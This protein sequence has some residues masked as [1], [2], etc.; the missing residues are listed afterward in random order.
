MADP[1]LHAETAHQASQQL[2]EVAVD[3]CP[4]ACAHCPETSE[5]TIT[6]DE[7]GGARWRSTSRYRYGTFS[8]LIKCPDGN[9]SG[10]NFNIYLSSLE[11][12][13]SQDEIDFEFLGKDK[14]IVQTNYYTTGTGS[15]EEIHELGF[16]CSDDF[17]EYTI[18]WFPDVIEWLIDGKVV[19]RV[20]KETGSAFPDKPMFLYASVW[21]ASYIDEGRWTGPYL[22]YDSP[23]V[24]R[25]RNVRVPTE[26]AIHAPS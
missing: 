19:R 4:E 22:A 7:R 3:Y 10:L 9:T 18:K 17:H 26:T 21:D 11:G 1:A 8:A 6:F 23:Y 5:I 20:E 14:T 13:K 15:R 24:C 2:K 25:Y 12:D 16:E